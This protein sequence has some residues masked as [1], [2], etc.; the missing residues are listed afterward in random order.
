[1]QMLI[2][3]D[4]FWKVISSII[5]VFELFYRSLK[6]LFT[7]ISGHKTAKTHLDNSMFQNLKPY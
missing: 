2:S 3:S 1:M 6:R 5:I 4:L 7:Y